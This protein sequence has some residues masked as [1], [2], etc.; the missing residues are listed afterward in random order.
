[1]PDCRAKGSDEGLGGCSPPFTE[2][3]VSISGLCAS[4]ILLKQA[5]R[6]AMVGDVL[7]VL[8]SKYTGYPERW[9]ASREQMMKVRS[10]NC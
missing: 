5:W 8:F 3:F 1:V 7:A 6:A 10:V 9:R 2:G 4:C